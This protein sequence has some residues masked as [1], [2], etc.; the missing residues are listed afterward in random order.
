MRSIKLFLVVAAAALITFGLS[1][2]ALAF[3]AGGVAHCD[4]CHT[5]HN[6]VDLETTT[7]GGHLTKGASYTEVCLNC[8]AGQA[9]SYYHVLSTDGGIYNPGGDFYWLSREWS[10]PRGEVSR[11]EDHGHNVVATELGLVADTTLT[12]APGGSY[13]ATILTC[14]SCHDPHGKKV[15]KTAPV[16]A[17][18]SYGLDN[19]D[20][21]VLTDVQNGDAV[22]GNFRLLADQG[23]DAGGGVVFGNNVPV[24]VTAQFQ[25]NSATRPRGESNFNHTDYGQNMSEWCQTCHVSF[26][27]SEHPVHP[28]GNGDGLSGLEQNYNI[29]VKTGDMTGNFVNGG[30][31]YS[32]V[33]FERHTGDLAQLSSDNQNG[34]TSTSNVMCLTC[35]R[36]HASAF[37]KATRWDT[38]VEFL[39]E[40][41]PNGDDDNSTQEEQTNSYYGVDVADP[42]TGFGPYQRSLCNKCHAKD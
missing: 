9:T 2:N 42:T 6:S 18:S 35:H 30:P 31:F 19:L 37:R 24:A 7:V 28:A 3:H 36:A 12:H 22:L 17:S 39:A 16:A 21:D 15:N 4:G 20:P 26:N 5:M 29:Y 23:Y 27:A 32:L 8:H 13:S 41:H 25:L 34:A 11:G 38:T 14:V 10:L 33:P 40:S 1:G